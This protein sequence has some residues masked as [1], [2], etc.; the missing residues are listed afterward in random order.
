MANEPMDLTTGNAALSVVSTV[1]TTRS[2]TEAAKTKSSLSAFIPAAFMATPVPPVASHRGRS[3]KEIR[4][5]SLQ[6][7]PAMKALG[8]IHAMEAQASKKSESAG[9]MPGGRSRADGAGSRQRSFR[10][11]HQRDRPDRAE[12][13]RSLEIKEGRKRIFQSRRFDGKACRPTSAR[14]SAATGEK[15]PGISAM[16]SSAE[17]DK[18]PNNAVHRTLTRRHAMCLVAALPA[19][20]APSAECR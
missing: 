12:F 14:T 6:R 7:K 19:H 5:A 10:V 2:G 15:N 9:A 16:T 20:A 11:D 13:D 3:E 17:S 18:Y 1:A 4:A 8:H